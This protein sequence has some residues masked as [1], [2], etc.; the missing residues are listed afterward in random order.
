MRDERHY[1]AVDLG[2]ESGRVM[3]AGVGPGGIALRE[4]HRFANGPIEEGGSLRWDYERLAG[5]VK[6]GVKRALGTGQK[7][8]SIGIDTWGVD[9]GLVDERGRLLENPYHYR[10][11]RTRGM[12][13]R[14]CAVV[15]RR[16]IYERTGTQFLPFNTLY[17][18]LAYQ[19]ERPGVLKRARGLRF[20]ADLMTEAL[21]GTA[22][23][24]YTLAS[25]SQLMDMRTGE[26]SGAIGEA[27]GLPGGLLGEVVRPGAQAGVLRGGLAGEWGCGA[28]PVAAVGTHDTASAV[29]GTPGPPDAPWV[30]LSSG[31]WSLMGIET[32]R[33]IINDTTYEWGFT[34]E[35]GVEGTIRVLK[36]IMG[37]WLVQECRR[38]WARQGEGL[39]YAEAVR[40][41]AAARAE[42]RIEVDSEEF[43]SPGEMPERINR[44]LRAAGQETIRDK[45][46][47]VR[48]ILE[49]LARRYG[50]VLGR[51]EGLLG[52]EIAVVHV[53]G[54]GCQNELLNQLTAD[55]TGRRVVAGPVEATV[56][57][58]VL[59]QARASGQIGSL[60]EGR[61][62]VGRSFALREYRPGGGD[63]K[64][65]TANG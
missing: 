39:E 33:A 22:A 30:Y 18:L 47:M 44:H 25:T 55:A 20:M 49:S 48:A 37:L 36:N 38:E 16:E 57:G 1:I 24:E 50:E 60:G 31:T 15:G 53:V 26:W 3:L 2:A 23:T 19:R 34:N 63:G 28:V 10:D 29:A 64:Y 6:A 59:L 21:T 27:F 14:A 41:A 8:E 62:L 13:E 43:L 7:V 35:G 42:A 65:Q 46:E 5:E 17:Q 12:I 9:F 61:E 4:V 40:R 54:G 58:N 11:G 32:E 56:L 52:G 45:G 51:L